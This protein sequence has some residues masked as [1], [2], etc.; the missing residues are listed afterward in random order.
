MPCSNMLTPVSLFCFPRSQGGLCLVIIA[1][2][3]HCCQHY[4]LGLP[5]VQHLK[6]ITS[7]WLQLFY[8]NSGLYRH[9]HT[10]TIDGD[11]CISADG[12]LLVKAPSISEQCAEIL[13]FVYHLASVHLFMLA[14]CHMQYYVLLLTFVL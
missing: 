6:E 10:R 8:S 12:D 4:F 9:M 1:P 3:R 13:L 14:L 2:K 11:L 5:S 7:G